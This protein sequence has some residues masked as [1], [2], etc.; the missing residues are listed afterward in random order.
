MIEI[1]YTSLCLLNS[2]LPFLKHL[3]CAAV[4]KEKKNRY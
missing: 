4:Q 2:L 3:L 1:K